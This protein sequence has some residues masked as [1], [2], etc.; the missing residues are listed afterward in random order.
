MSIIETLRSKCRDCYKCLRACPVK[1]IKVERGPGIHEVHASVHEDYCTYCGTCLT[2]CPQKAK[3]ARVDT[4][5][6]KEFLR[7][8]EKVAASIAPSFAASIEHPMRFVT[9]LRKA[10]FSIVQETALGA[11]MVSAYHRDL[12]L[13]SPKKPYIGSACPAVVSLVQKH[14]PEAIPFLA[15]VVSPAIA[16]GKYLKQVT[17]GVKVVFIGPC[18]AKKDEIEDPAVAGAVDV[19]LTFQ[20]ALDWLKTEGIKVAKCAV[21]K[22]DGPLPSKARLY[23]TDGGFLY[24]TCDGGI[25]DRNRLSVSGMQA[26]IETIRHFLRCKELPQLAELLAC[27]GGCLAGPSAV[28]GRDLYEKRRMLLAYQEESAKADPPGEPQDYAS[29]L[30][31][32]ALKRSFRN[33][34]VPVSQP[35]EKELREILEKSGKYGPEDEL[36]C[37]ACGYS[38]CRDKA[39]AAFNGMADPVMCIPFMRQRAE[40][41]ANVVVSATPDGIIV[42]TLDGTIVDMNDSAELITGRSKK[43]SIG[44]RVA[45]IMD[46]TSFNEAARTKADSRR[47]TTIGNFVV[48]EQVLYVP[49]QKL[50]VAIL[51]DITEPRRQMERRMRVAEEAIQR[52]TQVIEKQMAVAQKIAGV[53]GE[54]TAETKISLTALINVIGEEMPSSDTTKSGSGGS[55]TQ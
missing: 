12:L 41:M 55:S 30:P 49:D 25:M 10:G 32:E 51:M 18:I 38:S 39:V 22:F 52:A 14:Y 40:S 17:P 19:A 46:A 9:A 6:V 35:S 47:E 24:A 42:T 36:N 21:G 11:E 16:H 45:E 28:T 44:L 7:H 27:D 43:S 50:L 23:P 53:L 5:R 3:K 33:L 31:R 54:T 34:K 29:L 15:P 48:D 20:E 1:A 13:E 8:G 37:G 26:A 2:E 4:D